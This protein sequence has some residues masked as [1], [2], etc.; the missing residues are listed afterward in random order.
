MHR[1]N[2]KRCILWKN[3]KAR[4]ELMRVYKLILVLI[5]AAA[6][7]FGVWYCYTTYNEQRSTD[8]GML[9]YE[10]YAR[11]WACE[12]SSEKGTE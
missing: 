1:K 3:G 10:E 2:N 12:D 8:R 6:F 5:I 4:K 9:V 11:E 7:I